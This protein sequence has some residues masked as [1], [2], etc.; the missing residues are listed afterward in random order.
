[1]GRLGGKPVP[2]SIAS[3]P[4]YTTKRC[5]RDERC[6]LQGKEILES[7]QKIVIHSEEQV[8]LPKLWSDDV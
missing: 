3:Q 5:M 6:A 4:D 2:L 7:S 8:S 1:M